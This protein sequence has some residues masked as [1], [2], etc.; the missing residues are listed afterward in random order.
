MTR[1]AND[2]PEW[3]EIW[4]ADHTSATR[5]KELVER[6]RRARRG[7]VVMRLLPTALALVALVVVALA[8]GHA[9]NVFEITLGVIVA[10]GIATVWNMDRTNHRQAAEKVDA[11]F[12]E[13]VATRRELCV[14]RIAFA[15]LAWIVTALDLVFLVPWWIGGLKVHGAGFHATQVLTI[16]GPLAL[17]T[18]VVWWT[19]RLR[20]RARSELTLLLDA[21]LSTLDPPR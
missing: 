16:W 14:R 18:G 2:W 9:G 12:E 6:T 1:P 5:L 7:L 11:P 4:R 19:A 13:Y 10:I 21:H 3:E 15:Q 20:R 17:M 8:L